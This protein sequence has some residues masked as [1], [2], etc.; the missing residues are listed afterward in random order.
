MINWTTVFS[1]LLDLNR[2]TKLGKPLISKEPIIQRSRMAKLLLSITCKWAQETMSNKIMVKSQWLE[3]T[4]TLK[5]RKRLALL[6]SSTLQRILTRCSSRTIVKTTSPHR[7]SLMWNK[8]K[9]QHCWSIKSPPSNSQRI[10]KANQL[11]LEEA[12]RSTTK[13]IRKHQ[14]KVIAAKEVKPRIWLLMI[15]WII[16]MSRLLDL[17]RTTEFD[18]PL[19]S[20]EPMK[21]RETVKILLSITCKWA[22]ETRSNRTMVKSQ[23]LEPTPTL[24]GRKQLALLT[25][26][27]LQR[28]LTRSSSRI[29]VEETS[30]WRHSQRMDSL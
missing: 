17:I 22:R 28:I 24:M 25:S 12:P 3:P 13:R 27:T 20:K 15:S 6:A 29:T 5:G 26:S 1:R 19:I 9:I 10:N 7:S 14:W 8:P 30:Q 16:K 11:L 18:K 23:W 2:T 21:R 4:Q